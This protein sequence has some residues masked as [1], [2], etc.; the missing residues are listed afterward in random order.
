MHLHYAYNHFTITF[1]PLGTHFKGYPP[2]C[3]GVVTIPMKCHLGV[4][5]KVKISTRICGLSGIF[6]FSGI[7]GSPPRTTST[8]V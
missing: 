1:N 7:T 8:H 5:N 3:P 4:L 2:P 6:P